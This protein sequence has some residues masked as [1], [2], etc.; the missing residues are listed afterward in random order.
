MRHRLVL[1]AFV[2]LCSV[3]LPKHA[4]S[5]SFGDQS[6]RQP[7]FLLAS[8][9]ARRRPVPIDVSRTPILRTR[10]ALNLSNATLQEA[11]AAVVERSGLELVYSDDVLPRD[12]R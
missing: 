1:S 11:L 8:L 12:S 2:A 7:R 6:A 5:Q 10:I 9:D 3:L 4:A